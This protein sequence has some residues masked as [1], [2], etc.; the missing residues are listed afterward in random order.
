MVSAD[1]VALT[2]RE[3]RAQMPPTA[4]I[5]GAG[6]KTTRPVSELAW[7]RRYFG[8]SVTRLTRGL[9]AKL[10]GQRVYVLPLQSW[11][12]SACDPVRGRLKALELVRF[13]KWRKRFDA[14]AV[15]GEQVPTRFMRGPCAGSDE[16]FFA[17]GKDSLSMG[18]GGDTFYAFIQT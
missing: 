14:E 9:A 2:L 12:E 16:V 10:T 8:R 15:R 6:P 18:T 4:A 7:A 5:E 11:H 1:I 3:I 17:S 13:L